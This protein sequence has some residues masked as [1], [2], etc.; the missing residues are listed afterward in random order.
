[1]QNPPTR[2]LPL[3]NSEG[4]PDFSPPNV[5][6]DPPK[7]GPPPKKVLIKYHKTQIS[8]LINPFA[9][10]EYQKNRP[11]IDFWWT[12]FA[13]KGHFL[14]FFG[15]IV[16]FGSKKD[17]IGSAFRSKPPV[18]ARLKIEFGPKNSAFA[19]LYFQK[20]SKNQPSLAS[21]SDH[22][23]VPDFDQKRPQKMTQKTKN[24]GGKNGN[25]EFRIE[26]CEFRITI[27]ESGRK[28]S[29]LGW[30]EG[31]LQKD[32]RAGYDWD[33]LMGRGRWHDSRSPNLWHL[34]GNHLLTD[35]ASTSRVRCSPLEG[36]F[37]DKE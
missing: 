18:F 35:W 34:P 32:H 4:L 7:K 11:W 16:F 21:S 28:V 8:F 36:F 23:I 5:I 12:F 15:K 30:S 6:F 9:K 1:M 26:N 29:G 24:R 2:I 20:G 14:T 10:S 27:W 13:K 3:P 31:D 19:R 25:P 17:P 33:Q 37:V 22:E